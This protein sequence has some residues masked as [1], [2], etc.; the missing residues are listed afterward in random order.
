LWIGFALLTLTAAAGRAAEE[1]AEEAAGTVPAGLSYTAEATASYHFVNH[2]YFGADWGITSDPTHVNFNWGEGFTRVRLNYG[3]PQGL[4]ASAGGVLMATAATD[5]Y[6]TE[7][8]GDG[9]LDQLVV[10]ASDINGSG[11]SLAAGRQDLQV[12]D[13]FLI[14]DGYRDTRAALWNIPLNFYDALR[15]DWAQGDW[16]ALAFGA[17][18]SPSYGGEGEKVKGNQFGLETGWSS[19]EERSLALGYFQRVDDGDAQFD[20]QAFSLR[21]AMGARGFT[22][23]GEWV[24]ESGTV[25]FEDLQGR[26]GHLGLKYASEGNGEPYAQLEYFHFSGDDPATPE[27]EAFYPWNYR[28]TDWS[29]YYVGDLVAS[30]LLTNSDARIW[31]LECG[32]AP[33][34]NTGLRLLLHRMLLDTGASYGGL[35]DGVGREFADEADLVVD[36]ALGDH[37]SAWVM[38]AYVRPL[39]AAKALVGEAPSGQV[40]V[41]LTCKF[42][43]PGGGSED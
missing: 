42:G 23:A 28:W 40:F 1:A 7:G 15:A 10:G 20:A 19:G 11:L 27:N 5:Y 31:K 16:H 34:E 17:R 38:G 8:V 12:G 9:M 32:Y 30:T 25:G 3:L 39:E 24:M 43:G 2:P 13:G 21:G 14:G 22:L 37:W 26:G 36:Q 6:G 41:S 29:R 33:L 18:L 35:P 4:W